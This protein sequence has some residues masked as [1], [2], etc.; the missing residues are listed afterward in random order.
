VDAG[1]DAALGSRAEVR[2]PEALADAP[3]APEPPAAPP[4]PLPFAFTGNAS[5]YFRIWIVN[6]LLTVLTLGLWSP[7]A[8]VRKRRYFYGHTWVG[9]ANF[10][11]HGKPVVILRG[12]LLAASAFAIYWF[13]SHLRPGSGPWL[14]LLLLLA[15]PWIIARS[16]A[17]NA[18]NSSHRGIHFAFD[19]RAR[20]V[21]VAIW[22]LFLWPVV[23]WLTERDP[24][25]VVDNAMLYIAATVVVYIVLVCAY[26]YAVARVRRLTVSHSSWGQCPFASS[27]R[28]GQVYAIY[29]IALVLGL[30]GIVLMGILGVGAFF[31]AKHMPDLAPEFVSIAAAAWAGLLYVLLVVV[32]MG[33]TRSRVG[34]LVFNSARLGNLAR[35]KSRVSARRLA[36]LYGGNLFAI[37]FSAGLL[38][39]WAVIRVAR[40]RV[41][42]LSVL[43]EAAPDTVLNAVVG[44]TTAAGEE[45]GEV[46]GVDLA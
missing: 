20:A 16:L 2:A 30:I 34:N 29:G 19:G 8:K 18:A 13:V 5:A 38:I 28:T 37:Q 23:L 42:S 4:Q 3:V 40:Y 1:A 11:F 27:M 22:P 24:L 21:A 7:W 35:F 41:E 46:F 12:R 43:P 45:L 15:A 10:E 31:L 26:P 6:L 17:F 9:G 14:L 39:P 36:R 33:Y 32:V 44:R 25:A